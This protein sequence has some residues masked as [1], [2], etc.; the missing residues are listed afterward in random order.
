MK[1]EQLFY[2]L[3]LVISLFVTPKSDHVYGE[4][5][6]TLSVVPPSIDVR[7]GQDF[8]VSVDISDIV[9]MQSFQFKISW[10]SHFVEYVAH[11]LYP[12]WPPPI[13]ILDPVINEDEGYLIV[14]ALV[15]QGSAARFAGSV[16]LGTITFQAIKPGSTYVTISE[17]Q[18]G[19]DPPALMDAQSAQIT[20]SG[21]SIEWDWYHN[22]TEI[23]NTLFEMNSTYPEIVDVFSIG[24]SWQ[25]RD[26][27]CIRLTNETNTYPK[28]KVF[29]VGYHHAREP[30]TAELTLYFAVEAVSNYGANS[31]ITRMLD[32]S[33][34]YIVVALNVDGFGLFEANDW[35]RKN[36]RPT[37]ED[38]DGLV[39]EDPPEDEDQDGFVG[40]L[41]DIKDPQNPKFVRWEGI[42]NDGDGRYAEDWIGGVDL[43]RNY[44]AQWQGGNANPRSETYKG[45]APF[46]EPETQAIR[47]L[48]L[49]HNFTYAISFHSGTEVILY[50]WGYTHVSPP[51]KTEFIEIAEDLSSITGGTLYESASDLY[52]SYGLWDDWL[53]DTR[54][55]FA[56]TCEIFYNDTWEG[57]TKPGPYPNTVWEGG[58]KYWFNPFPSGIES[59]VLRWL[60]V[61][62][63]I[64]DKVIIE[65]Y[66]VAITEVTTAKKVV[67]QEFAVQIKATAANEGRFTETFNVTLYANTTS[68][69]SQ[70]VTI[71]S[72]NSTT[73]TF[74]WN[75]TGFA[76]GNYGIS[77]HAWPVPG[78]LDTSDNNF[79]DDWVIVAM[80][81]DLTGPTVGVPDGKIDIRDVALVGKAFGSEIGQLLYNPNCDVTGPIVGLE[82]G[83]IDIRDIALVAR[84]FGKTEPLKQAS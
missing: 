73:I 56:F 5:R 80:I 26:I 33:E 81:G 2:L 6:A 12:R 42:D 70:T 48:V 9:G 14:G 66:D 83:K 65:P 69:A 77:A 54:D 63:Y 19:S 7:K 27:Y 44:D 4:G 57:A 15:S 64:T 11:M 52:I 58:L 38:S 28:P 22:Y 13:I 45:P 24:K 20:I 47:K 31:T 82:D 39:D 68:I 35:Q 32:Y 17:P 21:M 1:A 71:T 78:E 41:I 23:V 8:T 50:P 18:I 43:N 37:D 30:I 51:D 25:N 62:Y 40:Q 46:S 59:T 76:K 67:G 79:T 29:F 74:T 72:R 60:P 53:Y 49:E 84:N 61:F 55:V 16:T 36:A 34:I 10:D 3:L 75:T